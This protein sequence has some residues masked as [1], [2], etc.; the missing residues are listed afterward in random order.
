MSSAP[1]YIPS[2]SQIY[3][4]ESELRSYAK[5]S[6]INTNLASKIS[7]TNGFFNNITGTSLNSASGNFQTL[8][9]NSAIGANLSVNSLL[10]NNLNLNST[11]NLLPRPLKSVGKKVGNLNANAW[12]TIS[13]GSDQGFMT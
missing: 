6:Y 4:L 7:S 1:I 8:T 12:T 9:F 13:S 11:T 5:L 3:A 2:S 10:L